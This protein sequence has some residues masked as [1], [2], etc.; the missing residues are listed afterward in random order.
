MKHL[1]RTLLILYFVLPVIA[2]FFILP[3]VNKCTSPDAKSK[4][5]GDSKT[6]LDCKLSPCSV[7]Y[8]W[9]GLALYLTGGICGTWWAFDVSNKVDK[10]SSLLIPSPSK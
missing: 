6:L 8:L 9:I 5:D 4:S 2:A 3:V 10:I 7:A 1:A